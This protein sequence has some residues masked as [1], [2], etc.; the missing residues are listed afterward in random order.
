VAAG[1]SGFRPKA[2][3][4]RG[5]LHRVISE[6]GS[7]SEAAL[8]DTNRM[9]PRGGSRRKCTRQPRCSS[10]KLGGF[11][12]CLWALVMSVVSLA[13]LSAF[14]HRTVMLMVMAVSLTL[15]VGTAGAQAV[16]SDQVPTPQD[17]PYP[18]TIK[19]QVDASDTRQGIFRVHETIPVQAGALTLLYPQWIPGD[20]GPTGPIAMLAG[21]EL[22]AGLHAA[23]DPPR[24]DANDLPEDDG[25]ALV[26]DPHL[27]ALVGG[28]RIAV[29]RRQVLPPPEID[30][31]H[32]P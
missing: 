8:V 32:P 6:Q 5:L 17:T 26:I 21:L 22:G 13:E 4:K 24:E 11:L 14:T 19:L 29:V 23:D 1:L 12:G 28:R 10:A 30:P 16:R 7:E 9:A 3:R 20:H 2:E 15:A 18:G 31:R 27:A 25:Q